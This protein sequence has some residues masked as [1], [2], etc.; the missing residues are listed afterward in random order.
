[1]VWITY[2]RLLL[3]IEH[4]FFAMRQ[5]LHGTLSKATSHFILLFR[6]R[7]HAK[8]DFLGSL[9]DVSELPLDG[10]DD[11]EVL[12]IDSEK[13]YRLPLAESLFVTAPILL[14]CLSELQRAA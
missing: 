14:L 1:M 11:A 4:S 9:F 7:S 12:K 8:P 3:G 10:R 6:H 5:L 13:L 2:L